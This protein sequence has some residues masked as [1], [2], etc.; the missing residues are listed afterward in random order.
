VQSSVAGWVA[1]KTSHQPVH[2]FGDSHALVF[3][4]IRRRGA[5]AG[6][7]L[8]VTIVSGATALG[9]AN[10]LSQTKALPR[11]QKV[12][13]RLDL[14]RPLVF[15]LGEVDC[16][17]LIW[18]RAQKFGVSPDAEMKRSLDNYTDFLDGL[19]AAGRRRLIV[20]AAPPPTIVDGQ[21]WGEIAH[22]RRS[23]RASQRDRTLMTVAYNDALSDWA[24]LNKCEFL[25]YTSDVLDPQSMLVSDR[26]RNEDPLDHHLARGPFAELM[27]EYL[28]SASVGRRQLTSWTPPKTNG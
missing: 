17:F 25:D 13:D 12:I 19:L 23:I 9:L 24:R 15:M 21:D 26:Y 22:L 11:F 1:D 7:W 16:G 28:K 27:T 4:D 2:C 6:I 5:P 10:P 8:D 3:E 14:D 20:A 18:Y